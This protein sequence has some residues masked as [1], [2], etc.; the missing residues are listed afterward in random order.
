[1]KEKETYP[2]HFIR[3]DE[4]S[5]MSQTER[6]IYLHLTPVIRDSAK[7]CVAQFVKEFRLNRRIAA[8]EAALAE[9]GGVR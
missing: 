1:M 6:A 2:N 4:F 5:G 3:D 9:K 7:L 8:L